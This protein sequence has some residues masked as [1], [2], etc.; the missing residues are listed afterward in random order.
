MFNNPGEKIKVL[1]N[2]FFWLEAVASVISACVIF[3][4]NEKNVFLAL[5]IAVGGVPAA[6]LLNVFLY[7]IGELFQN[8]NDIAKEYY[9]EKPSTAE[10]TVRGA[11]RSKTVKVVR[12]RKDDADEAMRYADSKY[13]EAKYIDSRYAEVKYPEGKHTD[14]RYADERYFEGKYV[15]G[16][17]VDGKYADTGYFGGKYTDT[18]RRGFDE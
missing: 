8:I 12:Y 4:M 11:K 2:I 13:P 3:L 7:G 17:Y 6:W 5:G 18:V 16:K 10:E 15:D 1:A 14:S 9:T